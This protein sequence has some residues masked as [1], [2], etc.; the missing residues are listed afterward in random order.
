[1]ARSDERGGLGRS[2]GAEHVEAELRRGRRRRPCP[3]RLLAAPALRRPARSTAR[4][5]HAS[6]PAR[7]SSSSSARTVSPRPRAR[8]R[9]HPTRRAPRSSTRSAARAAPR[10]RAASSRSARARTPSTG[11]CSR[12]PRRRRRRSPARRGR[13]R[14][15]PG[16]RRARARS[17]AP[18]RARR[19]PRRARASRGSGS[20]RSRTRRGCG[21]VSAAATSSR[22]KRCRPRSATQRDAHPVHLEV[23]ERGETADEVPLVEHD[24]VARPPVEPSGEQAEPLARAPQESDLVGSGVEQPRSLA[25]DVREQASALADLQ[26][27]ACR[28]LEDVRRGPN[29]AGRQEPLRRVVE[30]GQLARAGNSVARSSRMRSSLSI[31]DTLSRTERDPLRPRSEI[32]SAP[33]RR[34]AGRAA[35]R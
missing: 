17:P 12:G 5:T 4:A 34:T 35:R 30:V 1:M 32:V 13:A 33:A 25:S 9:S 11:T 27:S 3:A 19:A 6:R 26:R 8:P 23:E 16:Q 31:R 28:S 15:S 2:A 10:S 21:C 22:S 24:L 14:P 29:V 7:P 18:G 20:R